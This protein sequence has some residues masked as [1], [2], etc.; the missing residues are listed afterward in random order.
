MYQDECPLVPHLTKSVLLYDFHP[1]SGRTVSSSQVLQERRSEVLGY[2]RAVGKGVSFTKS[3]PQEAYKII[4]KDIGV[5]PEEIP[6]QLAGIRVMDIEGN[7]TIPFNAN[8]SLSLVKS[9][10]AA[11][12]TLKSLGK[13]RNPNPVDA[14]TLIDDSLIKSL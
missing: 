7:K 1:R 14:A 11:T 13:T 3:N 12:E 9:L 5:K 6:A 2:M 10:R 4:A 8:H